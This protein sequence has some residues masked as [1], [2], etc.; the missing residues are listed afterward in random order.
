[1]VFVVN[2]PVKV[3]HSTFGFQ[4]DPWISCHI[5]ELRPNNNK[6]LNLEMIQGV[7][8][9]QLFCNGLECTRMKSRHTSSVP[10][11]GK[12][13][14]DHRLEQA[15]ME[16][17]DEPILSMKQESKKEKIVSPEGIEA[18]MEEAMEEGKEGSTKVEPPRISVMSK[19]IFGEYTHCV[20]LNSCIQAAVS[21]LHDT[22]HNNIQRAAERVRLLTQV[23]P[24]QPSF[25]LGM[26][27]TPRLYQNML[28]LCVF[29]F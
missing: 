9:S 3:T 27:S 11:K 8:I 10:F 5:D 2:L 24:H 12:K 13:S 7:T 25:P 15:M 28:Y 20:H 14:S 18:M 26:L 6:A 21:R 4:G 16:N 1:M 29:S 23:I 22:T 19:N 17:E